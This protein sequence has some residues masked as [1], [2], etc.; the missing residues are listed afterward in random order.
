M[1][2]ERLRGGKM[3][4]KNDIHDIKIQP[5]RYVKHIFMGF[6]PNQ[7]LIQIYSSIPSKVKLVSGADELSKTS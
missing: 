6:P 1:N 7:R 3:R 5:A 4:E 2:D